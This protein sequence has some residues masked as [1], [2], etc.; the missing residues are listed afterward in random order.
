MVNNRVSAD[1]HA[2]LA[3]EQIVDGGQLRLRY[4]VEVPAV[5][6]AAGDGE[7]VAHL[8]RAAPEGVPLP[9]EPRRDGGDD[10]LGCPLT[11]CLV[12]GL[13]LE[14]SPFMASI[15]RLYSAG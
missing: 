6:R 12:T 2:V 9:V 5:G 15:I 13:A 14:L 11:G 4:R 8:L 10:A 7:D 1:V 3:A